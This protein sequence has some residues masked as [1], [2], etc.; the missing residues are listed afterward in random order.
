M[1]I[2]PANV[3]PITE[4]VSVHTVEQRAAALYDECDEDTGKLRDMLDFE[5]EFQTAVAKINKRRLDTYL[6][7]GRIFGDLPRMYRNCLLVADHAHQIGMAEALA[8]YEA[9]REKHL[10]ET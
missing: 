6:A 8:R 5:Q 1:N 4:L 10:E 9:A 2:R 3:E 7:A